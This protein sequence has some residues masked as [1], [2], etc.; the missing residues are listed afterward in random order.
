M[1][2]ISILTLFF[3]VLV[4]G[5]T[6]Q[7]N[8]SYTSDFLD[9]NELKRNKTSINTQQNNIDWIEIQGIPN[10]NGYLIVDI[11]EDD[12][13]L[14]IFKEPIPVGLD[15]IN[16]NINKAKTSF[17]SMEL[18][19]VSKMI[20]KGSSFNDV[21]KFIDNLNTPDITPFLLKEELF[22]I[23]NITL[24]NKSQQNI[25]YKVDYKTYLHEKNNK[26]LQRIYI[27]YEQHLLLKKTEFSYDHSSYSLIFS[28]DFSLIPEGKCSFHIVNPQYNQKAIKFTL[29]NKAII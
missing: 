14:N 21:N 4:S 26:L 16:Y 29:C 17:L 15:L 1:K 3:S 12:K 18:D 25:V 20:E 23:K 9:L 28:H 7:Y 6:I 5:C 11:L 13:S 24:T 2:K 22:N 19:T 27:S 8:Q 10:N